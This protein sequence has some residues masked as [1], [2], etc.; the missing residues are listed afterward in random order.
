M[1]KDIKEYIL[2]AAIW[3]PELKL[4]KDLSSAR[5]ANCDVGVVFCGH[6]H[7]NCIHQMVNIYGIYQSKAGRYIQGF[8]TSKNRFVD[9]KEAYEI[10]IANGNK[11]E[12]VNSLFSEDLY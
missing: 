2:C 1:S 8:L 5:P 3:Y 4:E 9:R 12:F 10:H 7:H 6:R 11:A